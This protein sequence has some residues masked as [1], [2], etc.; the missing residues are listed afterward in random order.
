MPCYEEDPPDIHPQA[1]P[2]RECKSVC[3][4]TN[5]IHDA[6]LPV[7]HIFFQINRS[8][9]Q[10]RAGPNANNDESEKRLL[11]KSSSLYRG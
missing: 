11:R 2:R 9:I 4:S 7:Y 10:T 5:P 6:P 1:R 3:T 8:I